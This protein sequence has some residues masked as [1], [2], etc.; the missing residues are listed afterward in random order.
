MEPLKL[1][2]L[3]ILVPFGLLWF[4]TATAYPGPLNQIDGADIAC[5]ARQNSLPEFKEHRDIS[6]ALPL[7]FVKPI[8][9]PNTKPDD[10]DTHAHTCRLEIDLIG[11]DLGEVAG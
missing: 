4:E 10:R 5:A 1:T 11:T 6:H 3:V 2:T 9:S 8:G 7:V